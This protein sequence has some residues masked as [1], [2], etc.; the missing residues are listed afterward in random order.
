MYTGSLSERSLELI[1]AAIRV[2]WSNLGVCSVAGSGHDSVEAIMWVSGVV[3]GAEGT[4]RVSYGVLSLDYVSITGF[5]LGL[6]V[7][8]VGVRNSVFEFVFGV[9][10]EVIEKNLPKL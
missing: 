3:D 10:L 7:S 8:G 5:V 1:V 6:V 9:G 4:I 2:C